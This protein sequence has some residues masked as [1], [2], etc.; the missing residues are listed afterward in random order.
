MANHPQESRV[1]PRQCGGWL[2][3]SGASEIVQ[4]GVTASTEAEAQA[5]LATA[6]AAWRLILA[7]PDAASS[8]S[9]PHPACH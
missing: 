5:R 6:L 1:F 2:A 7:S 4:I 9:E 3:L 8:A